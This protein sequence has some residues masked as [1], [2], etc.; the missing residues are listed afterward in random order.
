MS[1]WDLMMQRR[2]AAMDRARRKRRVDGDETIH[3]DMAT[4]LIQKM[5]EVAEQD[6]H[7]N[8]ARKAATKKIQLLPTVMGYMKKLE[9]NV[10][11]VDSSWA[12]RRRL[13]GCGF[14]LY[15]G[16]KSSLCLL[17]A[18]LYGNEI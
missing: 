10:L 17:A 6:R 8:M 9:H 13:S 18:T 11:L 14:H 4:A 5:K 7:L 12:S 3:D 15:D 16:V 1:D 2:K